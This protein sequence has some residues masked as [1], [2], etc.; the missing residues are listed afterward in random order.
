[1]LLARVSSWGRLDRRVEAVALIGSRAR[2]R[3]R[4][5]SDV[6]LLVLASAAA[7]LLADGT[8]LH[9]FGEFDRMA[10]EPWGDVTSLRVCYHD[11][12]EVEFAVATPAWAR[13]PL[14][15][16]KQRVLAGGFR[17]LVDKTGCLEHLAP[18][19]EPLPPA[20]LPGL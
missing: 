2:G 10:T 12:L 16:G 3:A 13:P 5:D 9:A 19:G 4:A 1:M 18:P 20:N 8:W 17:V 7:P 6:D 14:D 11:G 15:A